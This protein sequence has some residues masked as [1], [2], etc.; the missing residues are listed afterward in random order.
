M[1]DACFIIGNP[2]SDLKW[3][4]RST[5]DLVTR[6]WADETVVFDAGSGD[7]HLF[8]LVASEGYNCLVESNLNV[9]ELVDVM[10]KRL[11]IDPDEQLRQYV[12]KLIEQFEAVGLIETA[13]S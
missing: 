12:E 13:E 5:D 2:M 3:K 9:Q 11:E 10:A 8:D 6:K 7:T 4:I 1:I